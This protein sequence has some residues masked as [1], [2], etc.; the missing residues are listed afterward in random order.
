M[1]PAVRARAS[2]TGERTMDATAVRETMTA[3]L[4]ALAD[5]GDFARFFADD[6]AIVLM[7]TGEVTR[8]REAV[9]DL[10][11]GLH[12]TA[13]AARVVVTQ[14]VC[15]QDAA[16]IE[17]QLVGSHVGEFAGVP[18]THVPVTMTYS[19]AYDLA[20]GQITELRAYLPLTATV[21]HLHEAAG[22]SSARS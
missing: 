17:A 16:A 7:E 20:G 18:P 12:T 11:V 3:Y 15:D 14:L 5:E 9:R 6:V 19:V 22:A 21:L 2:P 8:G 1:V 10:V 13:F 4:D